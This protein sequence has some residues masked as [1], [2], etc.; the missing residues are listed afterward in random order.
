METKN[1]IL[2][3]LLFLMIPIFAIFMIRSCDN[4][5][6]DSEDEF[7]KNF[8]LE[9]IGEICSIEKGE[10]SLK[11]FVTVQIESSNFNEHKK[12]SPSGVYFAV[13]SDK[14]LVFLDHYR[15]YEMGDKV[16]IGCGDNI[17]ELKNKYGELKFSKS[18]KKAML[19][20]VSRPNKEILERLKQGCD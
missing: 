5:L 4:K 8:E 16:C 10:G 20:D 7:F 13:Q 3:G 17:I 19:F 18:R 12:K 9:T 11:F 2:I 1:K 6:D 14:Y 15:N